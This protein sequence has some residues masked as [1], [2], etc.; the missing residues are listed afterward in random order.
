MTDPFGAADGGW[1]SLDRV[2]AVIATLDTGLVQLGSGYLTDRRTVVTAHH[3]TVD[4]Q[5]GRAAVSLQVVRATDGAGATPARVVG[6]PDGDVAVLALPDDRLWPVGAAPT[7]FGRV[8]RDVAVELRDCV[9][10]GFPMW[11]LDPDND[12]RGTVQVQGSIRV[13]E[14]G[15]SG[16]LVIRDPLLGGVTHPP[17]VTPKDGSPWGGMSGAVVFHGDLA[18][19]VV[20]QHRPWQ[21]DTSLHVQPLDRYAV[22]DVDTGDDAVRDLALALGLPPLASWP[23]AREAPAGPSLRAPYLDPAVEQAPLRLLRAEYRLVEFQS[24][25]EL[26]VLRGWARKVAAARARAVAV[27]TGLGGSGKT[28]LALELADRLALE[29]WDVGLLKAGESDLDFLLDGHA[30]LLVVIDY[31]DGRVREVTRLVSLLQRRDSASVIVA[32]GRDQDA[33]WLQE[34]NERVNGEPGTR[35]E[36]VDLP[37]AH[38]RPGDVFRTAV[39]GPPRARDAQ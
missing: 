33:Q 16:R 14:Q 8:K 18:V 11:Q 5:T 10:V 4:L 2:L 22:G 23:Q 26:T 15:G 3:C 1:V 20:V 37:P 39:A 6:D 38:P 7:L 25:D 31:A 12:F 19:G 28:R 24:R 29:H 36:A 21:G 9:A 34:I 27:I 35:F 17:G 13:L 32:T 30:A